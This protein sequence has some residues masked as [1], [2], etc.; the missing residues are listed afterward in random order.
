MK[1]FKDGIRSR[2]IDISAV[3][4]PVNVNTAMLV[5][6]LIW[7]SVPPTRNR[8]CGPFCPV[9]ITTPGGRGLCCCSS[10][11]ASIRLITSC[12]KRRN[13]RSARRVARTV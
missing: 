5:V 3:F 7:N 13:S 4:D 10:K 9:S 11:I 8:Q 1:G 12:G 2:A 6:Y